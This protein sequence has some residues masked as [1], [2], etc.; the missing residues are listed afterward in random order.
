MDNYPDIYAMEPELI[1]RIRFEL[2]LKQGELGKELGVSR[3][4]ILRWE[5]GEKAPRPLVVRALRDVWRRRFNGEP[6]F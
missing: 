6:N 3:N 4:T 2:N 1:R 5:A